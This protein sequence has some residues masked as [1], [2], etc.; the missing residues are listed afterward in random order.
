MKI[1]PRTIVV[2]ALAWGVAIVWIVPFMGVI[3]TAVRPTAEILNGWWI[4]TE[5]NP[6]VEN[7]VDTFTNPVFSMGRGM[8]NSFLVAVPATFIPMF[9]ATLSAY[10]FARFNFPSR[11][12]LFLTIVLFMAIPQQMVAIP[13][14]RIMLDLGLVSTRLGLLILHSAWALPWIL[15]FMRNFL[16]ALPIEVEEAARVDGASDFEVFY[17]VVLPMALPALASVAVLQFMWVWNDFF[18]AQILIYDPE[19]FLATQLIPKLG[20][21]EFQKD[22]GLLTAASLWVMLV[23]VLIYATLQKFYI[24]GMIGWTIKG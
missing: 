3:M 21:G 18:F 10:G 1:A 20:L 8:A 4:F 7:M 22:F 19:K 12:Y 9:V 23:P 13:I 11:D 16:G 5:F 17:K 2:H 6:T 14:F 15:L 24:R